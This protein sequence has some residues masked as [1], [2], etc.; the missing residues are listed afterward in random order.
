[1]RRSTPGGFRN[2]ALVLTLL[3]FGAGLSAAQMGHESGMQYDLKTEKTLTGTLDDVMTM[4]GTGAMSGTHLAL[5]TETETIH[6]H[7]GPTDFVKKQGI[8][9]A[10]GDSVAVTGSRIKGEGFEAILARTVEKG[11]T[12]ITLRDTNGMPRW[13]QAPSTAR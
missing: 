4:P 10:K 11:E 5:R 2:A 7:L 13:H 3:G 8:T 12:V 9:F 1:M 6:V